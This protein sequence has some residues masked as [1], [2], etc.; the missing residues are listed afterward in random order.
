MMQV[1]FAQSD[2][3]KNLENQSISISVKKLSEVLIDRQLEV[4]AETVS[5]NTS[6]LS[7]E[8]S[9]IV[10]EVS[11]KVGKQVSKGDVLLKLDAT[12]Y[13]LAYDLIQ[14]NLVSNAARTKQAEIR[15]TRANDLNQ[16]NYIAADDLLARQ[17]DLALL[18]AEKSSLLVS[19]KQ[20]QRNLEKTTIRAPFDGIVIERFA[21]IGVFVST[22]TPLFHLVQSNNSEVYADVPQHLS[23]SFSQ[24]E[25]IFFQADNNIYPVK[26][27]NLS[28]VIQKGTRTQKARFIFSNQEAPIGSSGELVWI[29]SEGL[30]PSDLIVNRNRRLGVFTVVNDKAVFIALPTA[31]EGRPVLTNLD[32]NTTIIIGGRDR[33]QDGDSVKVK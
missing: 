18:K 10:N 1:T 12:D 23:S 30:L 8:I 33:L 31:Q 22:G 27:L 2:S 9:G 24:T 11:T 28:S 3:Q 29:V 17:T 16:K 5:V 14:T 6:Q 4:P 19:S 20:A 26:L 13:Q 21:N 7:A 25:N 15:L 32:K